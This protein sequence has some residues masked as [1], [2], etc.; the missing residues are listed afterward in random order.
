M[1]NVLNY[2]AD[3][4]GEADSTNAI[5]AAINAAGSAG[6]GV[7]FMPEGTYRVK[8][9]GNNNQALLINKNGIV[10][11]GAGAEKTRIFN[12]EHN[13]RRKTIIR[14]QGSTSS[15]TARPSGST[16]RLI[17]SD[18]FTPTH[19][20]PV[21]S[22]SG[23]SVGDWV[24]LRADMTD[25]FAADHNMLDLW[26]GG[27]YNPLKGVTFQR[28]I[29]AINSTA[30]TIT[31]DVPIRYYLRPRDNARV[32]HLHGQLLNIGMEDFSIGNVQHPNSGLSTG[33]GEDHY[34]VEGTNA[35]EVHDSWAIRYD[36]VRDSWISRVESYL[37]TVNT[38]EAHLLSNGISVRQSN[39]V[40]IEHADFQRP[41]Y[42]GG[43]GNGYMYVIGNS[44]EILIRDSAARYSR[45]GFSIIDMGSSGIVFLRFLDQETSRQVVRTGATSGRGSDHHKYLSQSNLVDTSIANA[46][47]FE[48]KWR[49]N[50]GG[51]IS[52]GQTSV[53][54]VFW[55]TEGLSYWE[56]LFSGQYVSYVVRSDQA[57]H[58]YIIGTRGPASGI[59]TDVTAGRTEP[60]DFREGVG[61]GDTLS[62]F[63][64]YEDQLAGRLNR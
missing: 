55:N 4:T 46:S 45:H 21:S 43:G 61:M 12:D 27:I 41:L 50:S 1:F 49:G 17:T 19:V 2:G 52:H 24:M 13:M 35:Y 30:R 42:G 26:G 44:N 56:H 36:R 60:R 48:A 58:G 38:V 20:I 25:A 54:T 5:Q 11:R 7:V 31:I 51:S 34:T 53:H 23:F 62:P 63:S 9:Q 32:H 22:T 28:K 8:P 59:L 29:T 16:E 18:L 37:P 15:W 10:L 14:A 33:W 64:L 47:W 3:P 57:R 40:T 6:G 39:S